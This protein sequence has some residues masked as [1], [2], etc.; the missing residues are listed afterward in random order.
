MG[1]KHGQQSKQAWAAGQTDGR[2]LVDSSFRAPM[3][4]R[5]T[6]FGQNVTFT[7]DYGTNATKRITGIRPPLRAVF[8]GLVQVTAVPLSADFAAHAECTLTMVSSGLNPADCR[9]LAAVGA[10]DPDATRYVALTA[11]V[12][13]VA[14]LVACNVAATQSIPLVAGSSLTSGDGF[15]EFDP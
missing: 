15:L 14:G 10:L 3:L 7:V 2:P 9:R 4:W 5:V 8:P 6:A 13:N 11:S 1:P 12:V